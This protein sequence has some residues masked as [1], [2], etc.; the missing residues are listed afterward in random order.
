[1]SIKSLTI[2]CSSSNNLDP[3]YYNISKNLT[4]IIAKYNFSIVYGGG[5]VGIMGAIAKK[6]L[7]LRIHITGVIPQFLN[8]KEIMF[9]EINS[10]KIV[11]DMS[12]RKKILFDLGDAFL[13]LPGGT[14]TIEE[15]SEIISWKVLGLHNKPIIIFNINDFW[16]PLLEQFK[17]INEEN[18]GNINLQ[19]IY[20]TINSVEEFDNILK[21][22]KK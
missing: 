1:M 16:L 11:N 19:D 22:W 9:N 17:K 4:K 21:S 14:G 20:E 7:E 5:Q 6:A 18:F 13:A 12:E 15:I 2:F 10:L 8:T 3:D